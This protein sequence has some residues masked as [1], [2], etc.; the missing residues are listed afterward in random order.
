MYIFYLT[1]SENKPLCVQWLLKS[2]LS[3]IIWYLMQGI[4]YFSNINCNENARMFAII[5]STLKNWPTV[6]SDII[7]FLETPAFLVPLIIIVW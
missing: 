1:L 6:L 7:R 2:L 4:C 3:Q 5:S